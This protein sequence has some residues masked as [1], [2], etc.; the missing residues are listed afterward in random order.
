[1]CDIKNT[2]FSNTIQVFMDLIYEHC[3]IEKLKICIL[4]GE[5]LNEEFGG[6]HI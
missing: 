5:K 4:L 2:L 1:M 6:Y 3:L